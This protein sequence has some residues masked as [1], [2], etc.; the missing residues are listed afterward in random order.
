M[1]LTQE[2]MVE[3]HLKDYGTINNLGSVY[4]LWNN[5]IKC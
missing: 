1:K 5:K 2:Q 4:R 3:Q